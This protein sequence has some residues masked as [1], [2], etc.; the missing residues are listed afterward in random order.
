MIFKI[1]MMFKAVFM[2]VINGKF[3]KQRYL[4]AKS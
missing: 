1:F 3:V 4:S 2:L